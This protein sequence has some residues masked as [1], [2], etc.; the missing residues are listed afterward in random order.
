MK[1][2]NNKGFIFAEAIIISTVVLGA[3][4]LIYTQFMSIN[5][6]YQNSFKY[7][8]VDKL[9]ATKN[10]VDYLKTDGF[11]ELTKNLV[12]Y[13]DISAC[14]NTYF[15][16]KKYCQSLLDNLNV[17]TV[18]FTREDITSLKQRSDLPFEEEMKAFIKYIKPDQQER[19][20]I[21]VQFKD[22]TFASLKID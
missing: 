13:I 17:K 9:Y 12:D 16:E 20:R 14:S 3:L 1:K 4:I 7:N 19:Y 5:K 2:N 21:I 22:N 6:S 8:N 15:V 18:I 10:I 11:T